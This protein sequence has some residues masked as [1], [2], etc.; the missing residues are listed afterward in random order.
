MLIGT[1]I[2]LRALEAAQDLRVSRSTLAKWRMR[3]VGPRYHRCGP[4]LV[5]YYKDEIE[6]W[7]AQCDER[8][9]FQPG[10]N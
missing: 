7:L 6:A 2:R 5:F 4:R 10:T 3:G 9:G 1:R 8:D